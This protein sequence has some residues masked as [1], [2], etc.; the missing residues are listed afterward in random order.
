MPLHFQIFCWPRLPSPTAAV[1]CVA[2]LL[3]ACASAAQAV[4]LNDRRVGGLTSVCK[5]STSVGAA[6]RRRPRL[7]AVTGHS[8]N[9]E[10]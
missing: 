4:A 3:K 8:V 10:Q 5:R 2:T 1:T 7:R 9:G 6:G